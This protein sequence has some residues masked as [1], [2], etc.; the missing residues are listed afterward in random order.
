[1]VTIGLPVA[2]ATGV[3]QDRVATPSMWTVQA[4]QSPMPQPYFVPV[5]FSKSRSTQRRGIAGSSPR[6]VGCRLCRVLTGPWLT[7]Q[8]RLSPGE[9]LHQRF[10]GKGV[11][12][13]GKA[14]DRAANRTRKKPASFDDGALRR[15]RHSLMQFREE[16]RH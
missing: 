4:P 14:P 5:M 15:A 8:L 2:V 10:A 6:F 16:A 12:D 13:A 11:G 7:P 3:W 9:S 1:M